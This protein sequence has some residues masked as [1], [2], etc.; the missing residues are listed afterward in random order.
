MTIENKTPSADNNLARY[1][2]LGALIVAAFFGAYRYAQATSASAQADAP[3][4]GGATTAAAS[5]GGGSCCGGTTG[6]G[7]DGASASGAGGP[8]AS[9]PTASG[10]GGCCG[11]D[12]SASEPVQGTASLSGGVQKIDVKVTTSYSPN[13][14]RLKAGVP[15]EIT[16]SQ[17]QGCTA[18]V[19]SQDL[20]FQEDLSSGPK[21]VKLQGLSA[22][23]YQFACGMNMVQGQVVVQ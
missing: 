1:A 3:A 5:A 4:A 8:G 18:I 21:T 10:S 13:V 9:A 17:A 22:G 2:L 15:A 19:Q 6:A 12:P 16:F 7:A 20:G 11:S 23:T 14:I